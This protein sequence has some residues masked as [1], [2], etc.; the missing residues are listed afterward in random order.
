MTVRRRDRDEAASEASRSWD[1]E[2]ALGDLT[3]ES[4]LLVVLR[5]LYRLRLECGVLLREEFSGPDTDPLVFSKEH[6]VSLIER[7]P[8]ETPA[9]ELPD[10]AERGFF[11]PLEVEEGDATEALVLRKREAYV[12]PLWE[13]LQLREPD[14]PDWW[15]APLPFALRDRGRV[16]VNRTALAMFGPDLERLPALDLPERDEFLVELEGREAPCF[17]TFRRLEPDVFI[18]EDTTDDLLDAQELSWWASVG[19]AWAKLLEEEGRAWHRSGAPIEVEAEKTRAYP[20]EW[21]GRSMGYFCV[22]EPPVPTEQEPQEPVGSREEQEQDQD[23]EENLE[24]NDDEQGQGQDLSLDQDQNQNKNSNRQQDPISR[25]A[26]KARRKALLR[27]LKQENDVLKSIGPRTMGLLAA[28]QTFDSARLPASGD[29][30]G[31]S[32]GAARSSPRR[33]EKDGR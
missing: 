17:L 6:L 5:S 14:F 15:D 10:L 24:Q 29:E 25:Q 30:P 13:A 2:N 33:S 28:G 9:T 4:P 23:Q 31:R 7:T 1:W 3:A 19:R 32:A 27:K 20:C 22:E 21:E 18:L 26:R 16:C 8:P 12:E 11:R